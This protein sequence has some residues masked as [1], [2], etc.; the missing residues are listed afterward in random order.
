M[1]HYIGQ[2]ILSLIII[3]PFL[4]SCNSLLKCIPEEHQSKPRWFLLLCIIPFI[5]LIFGYIMLWRAIPNS[6]IKYTDNENIKADAKTLQKLGFWFMTL[7]IASILI[8]VFTKA[9]NSSMGNT[10]AQVMLGPLVLLLIF[11][12]AILVF[13]W[14]HIVIIKN[15]I[16]NPKLIN[17]KA[18]PQFLGQVIWFGIILYTL[19]IVIMLAGILITHMQLHAFI[20]AMIIPLFF[21]NIL[22]ITMLIFSLIGKR[23]ARTCFT[24]LVALG[25][26]YTIL[27]VLAPRLMHFEV[28]AVIPAY[29]LTMLVPPLFIMICMYSKR[30]NKYFSKQ[31]S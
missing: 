6:I 27:L 7:P 18:K 12:I 20:L 9:I 26:I 13:Y 1:Q 2:A 8:S 31:S 16:K 4:A 10:A 14:R 19:T 17:Q 15:K 25:L 23:W 3:L 28:D 24:I 5:G 11:N 21:N 29:S 22:P 30:A